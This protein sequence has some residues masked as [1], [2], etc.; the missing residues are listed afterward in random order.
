[1]TPFR[2]T[3]WAGGRPPPGHGV[4]QYNNNALPPQQFNNNTS[5]YPTDAAPP[6]TAP[7]NQG[8]Y[9]SNQGYFGG[10]QNGVELQPPQNVYQPQNGGG[11][12]YAPPP[13]PPPGKGADGIV[14]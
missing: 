5:T 8:F 11:Q 14:K 3:G 9:G 1:M 6:Y 10:Q 12:V 13:G 4:A 7:P 2:G